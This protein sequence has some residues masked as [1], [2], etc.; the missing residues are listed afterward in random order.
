MLLPGS[1]GGKPLEGARWRREPA[2]ASG[3][4]RMSSVPGGAGTSR[5][6]FGGTPRGQRRCQT[7]NP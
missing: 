6:W 7:L 1:G 4:K 5:A 2:Q 3:E